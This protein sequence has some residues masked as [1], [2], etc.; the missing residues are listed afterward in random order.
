MNVLVIA[1]HPDDECLGC[2]GA[3]CLHGARG[4][5]VDAVFLSSGEMALEHLAKEEAWRI[6]E[7]EAEAAAQVLGLVDLHFL[8]RSDWYVGDD[9]AAAAAAL[10]PILTDLEPSLVYLPHAG[11]S[12]PDHQAALPIVR[13]ALDGSVSA[14]PVIRAYEVWTP[15]AAYD[16]IEDITA[17]MRRK[18]AALRRHRS[19]IRQ[20]RYDRAIRGLNQY[21][22]ALGA[23]T[24]Y[25]EVFQTVQAR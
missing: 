4:D 15:L 22:G 23:R 16:D 7:A 25:A 5:R 1:P 19:Q 9:I 21:R 2:G 17:V 8:R 24:G 12:H 3:I 11:E 14:S 6:R 10:R 13:A 20:F 18:L